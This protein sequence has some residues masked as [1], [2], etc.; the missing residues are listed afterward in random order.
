MSLSLSDITRILQLFLP[1]SLNTICG[2]NTNCKSH[3]IYT[4]SLNT[5]RS[6][7]T[8]FVFFAFFF[9]LYIKQSIYIASWD[10]F[11]IYSTRRRPSLK[12]YGLLLEMPQHISEANVKTLFLVNTVNIKGIVSNSPLVF[13][14]REKILNYLFPC[15]LRLCLA[16]TL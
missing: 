9:L 16:T 10:D 1:Y 4:I 2:D 12:I 8:F 7:N 15:L 5:I 6:I 3:I 14:S 13:Q 11:E